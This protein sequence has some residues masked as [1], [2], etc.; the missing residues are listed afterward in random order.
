MAE[1]ENQVV[2]HLESDAAVQQVMDLALAMYALES[3][4]TQSER[5]E[6]V[7]VLSGNLED[8]VR[9]VLRLHAEMETDHSRYDAKVTAE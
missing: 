6:A 9:N 5:L 8:D 4:E 7:A 2:R 1:T 3:G